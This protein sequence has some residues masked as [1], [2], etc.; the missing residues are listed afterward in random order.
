MKLGNLAELDAPTR[1]R[2]DAACNF[3]NH[4]VAELRRRVTT[5]GVVTFGTALIVWLASGIDV[6]VPFVAAFAITF[7]TFAHANRGLAKWYKTMVVRRVV[8]AV[9]TGLTYDR[10]SSF[11]RDQFKNI[12]LFNSRVDVWKSE[13]QISGQRNEID[14]ALHEIRAARREKRGKQTVEVVVFKGHIV[15]LEFNKNFLGHTVVVPDREG[16]ILGGLF[17][18]ADSRR[19]KRLISLGNADFEN[20]YSVYASDDQEA[21]Y[22]LTPKLMELILSA[23]A[24]LGCELRLAFYQNSLYVTVPSD[25]DRFEVSMFGGKVTPQSVVGDLASVVALAEQLIDTLDLET[26]IWTRT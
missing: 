19:S 11:T 20:K 5:V 16:K 15:I 14:Y 24:R 25:Q 2:I 26:R 17:G 3:I 10:E 1:G 13:D 23:C 7:L 18:D 4:K 21:N 6:R 8:E 9:G 22:L 12:D